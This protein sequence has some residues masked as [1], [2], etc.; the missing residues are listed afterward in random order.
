MSFYC[1]KHPHQKMTILFTSS[2]CDICD[3]PRSPAIKQ[4][5]LSVTVQSTVSGLSVVT[6]A[7][8]NPA[9]TAGWMTQL[10]GWP[11]G[12]PA[13]PLFQKSFNTD[14]YKTKADLYMSMSY[15]SSSNGRVNKSGW[16]VIHNVF[17]LS[18]K[19]LEIDSTVIQHGI[20]AV[21]VLEACRDDGSYNIYLATKATYDSLIGT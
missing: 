14:V 18:I 15:S 11:S 13:Y 17:N 12:E 1:P 6:S 10:L 16:Y 2:V 8:F 9:D 5:E 4:P 20:S 3:P 21:N 7:Q 19:Q